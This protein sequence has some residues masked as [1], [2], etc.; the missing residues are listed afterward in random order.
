MKELTPKGKIIT[1]YKATDENMCCRGFQ[2]E[3]GKWY[4]HNDRLEMCVSGFH[5]CEYPSGPWLFYPEGRIFKCEAEY[6]LLS[7][8]PGADLKH[9]AKRIRLVKEIEVDGN[10]NTGDRNTGDGNTGD[11]NTGD[12]NTGNRN[13]GNR[14]TGY[15]NTGDRN[16]GD[17]NTGHRNTGDRNTG[18]RNTG[19]RNTGDRNT[20]HRNT[21]HRN[22]G[23]WNTGVGN[24][25]DWNTGDRNTGDRNTGHRNTGHRNTGDWNTG[26]R[27]TG[28]WNTGV[29]NTGV[30]NTGYGNCGDF[31]SGSL[32]HG[33]APFF[34]FN[35]PA[36]RSEVDFSLVNVLSKK[37]MKDE[38]I[39][40][41]PFLSLPNATHQRIKELHDEHKAA[42]AKAK[43]EVE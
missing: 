14:N 35:L 30:G 32:C 20:G 7:E 8:G 39:D 31:H 1:G 15:G 33:E 3:L 6:V 21:G 41:E 4:E 38:E 24:T 22:T 27:N 40:P 13:T 17:W 34:L 37:L 10:W 36:D 5:F 12:W 25:G 18:H 9:V 16:T 29:G 42:R 19:D 43:V 26:H 28:D 2:Y 23:D 11:W